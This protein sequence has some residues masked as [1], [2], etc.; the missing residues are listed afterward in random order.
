[1]KLLISKLSKYWKQILLI[2]MVL[3]VQ[4]MAELT[5]PDF[6]AK[7]VNVGIS[8]SGIESQIPIVMSEKTYNEVLLTSENPDSIKDSYE[9]RTDF[10]ENDK[11]SPLK[12]TSFSGNHYFL[13][14]R[15]KESDTDFK[16][17]MTRAM[18]L[19]ELFNGNISD[20]MKKN[21]PGNADALKNLNIQ[22]LQVMNGDMRKVIIAKINE[23][24]NSLPD[25]ILNQGAV[26]LVKDEYE[27][28]GVDTANLQKNYLMYVGIRMIGIA[29]A[30]LLAA[31]AAG[32]IASRVAAH[33]GKE[34]RDETFR[35]VL[36]FSN[37]EFDKFSTASLITRCNNDIQQVQNM[38]VMLLRMLF[39][40]PIMGIGGL[41][42][43]LNYNVSMAWVIGLAILVILG[44]VA[45]LFSIAI[46]MFTRAQKL[47]DRLQLVTREIL[48]GVLVIRAFITGKHEEDRL[49]RVNK[50]ITE[51]NQK[52]ANTMN[53][54]QPTLMIIMNVVSLLIIWVGAKE[55]NNNN[56]LVGDLM[57]FLQ[58]GMLILMSFLMISVVSLMLPRAQITLKRVNEVL[59]TK[60]S[61][62]NKMNPVRL[63]SDFKAR[64]EFRNTSYRFPGAPLN[65]LDNINLTINPKEI[66]AVIGS[67]G[68]GKS[69]FINLIPRF[70]DAT[71]GE[72]LI[73][74]I[75]VKDMDMK[76]LRDKIGYVPQKSSLFSGNILSNMQIGKNSDVTEER[77]EEALKIA[78]AEEFISKLEKGIRH[79]ITQGGTN[80]SG[81][82]KQRLS[83]ARAIASKPDIYIFD[84]SFSALDFKTDLELRRALSKESENSTV[85]IVTQRIGTIINADKIVVLDEGKIV[86][87]GTHKELLSNNE[88]YRQIASSQLREEDL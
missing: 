47:F 60:T 36:S 86:G 17:N 84:D 41:I 39:F 23:G 71:E 50:D 6:M 42:K 72:V 10:T 43:S 1:M 88:I 78:Q 12:G 8:Q 46:P 74:G 2:I 44:F 15:A 31:L 4:A 65:A 66:T 19:K 34:L 75:N 28:N 87:V 62:V 67:T 33:F 51:L 48:N 25:Q 18:F 3:L 22:A 58:Y 9:K 76:E 13:K 56:L 82:Q 85:I 61:I 64:I 7:I 52:I 16:K 45:L 83:I 53:M 37:I 68:S 26:R 24:L 11:N 80:V 70:I 32:F 77:V 63:P 40:A 14:D 5:L 59:E 54:M 29:L 21:I 38:L 55:I 73:D 20:D 30:A 57:A 69:T 35:K 79:D 49:E 81:G 27:R